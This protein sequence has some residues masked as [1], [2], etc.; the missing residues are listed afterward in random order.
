MTVSLMP[1]PAWKKLATLSNADVYEV[2]DD[3]IAILPHADAVDDAASA[4]ESLEFQRAP[5]IT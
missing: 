5:T 4:H 3:I 1:D 2:R